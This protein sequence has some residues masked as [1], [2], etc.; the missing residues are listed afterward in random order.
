MSDLPLVSITIPAYNAKKY[1]LETIESI[2][3]QDYPHIEVLVQDNCSTDGTWELLQEL[4][5][6]HT[7]IL[8]RQNECNV[9]VVDNFNRVINR[10]R[11]DFAM[12][13][14]SDDLLEPGFVRRCIETFNQ[15]PHI[16]IVTTNYFYFTGPRK[17]QKLI[18][19]EPGLHRRFVSGVLIANNFSLN[20]TLFKKNVLEQLREHGDPFTTRFYAFDWEFWFRIALANFEVYYV[21]ECL[22]NCRVHAASASKTQSLRVFKAIFLVM[23]LHRGAIKRDAA[24]QYRVKLMRF[25]M[26][27]AGHLL[28]GQSKDMR[29]MKAIIGE[30]LR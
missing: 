12:V 9:H 13:M 8:I 26:R 10:A 20:F 11:G 18:R 27:H 19:M 25:A 3:A 4:A 2:L 17:W 5:T 23:L 22:G 21:P 7:H 24:V 15:N 6:Q 16:D 1:I 14:G 29:L 28:R 30:L